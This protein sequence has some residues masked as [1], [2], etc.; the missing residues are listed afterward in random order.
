L[1]ER[2]APDDDAIDTATGPPDEASPGYRA[3]VRRRGMSRS[4]GSRAAT[5]SLVAA[6]LLVAAA[7]FVF[8]VSERLIVI[9][10]FDS[11]DFGWF[12]V[13]YA[14]APAVL[15]LAWRTAETRRQGMVLALVIGGTVAVLVVLLVALA[16]HRLDGT[17]LSSAWEVVPWALPG[18]IGFF[19]SFVIPSFT[20]GVLAQRRSAI[21][22]I[23]AFS[24]GV[25]FAVVFV[26]LAVVLA[27]LPFL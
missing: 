25:V 23:A 9:G 7:L 4:S 8:A 10:H 14:L 22:A 27:F 15:G 17:H 6:P 5:L 24:V 19:L 1:T 2:T 18:G 26:G 12:V 21:G 20:T 16:A 3:A 11:P 13:L